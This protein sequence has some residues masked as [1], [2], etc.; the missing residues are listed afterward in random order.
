MSQSAK[1]PEAGRPRA[2]PVLA[3]RVP[4]PEDE[5]ANDASYAQLVHQATLAASM[6]DAPLEP[7]REQDRLLPAA[8]IFRIIQRELPEGCKISRDAKYFMQVR[9]LAGLHNAKRSKAGCTHVCKR[10]APVMS[11]AR[12]TDVPSP[13]E[14]QEALSEFVCFMTRFACPA[15][16][17]LLRDALLLLVL[18][19]H[20]YPAT[21]ILLPAPSLPTTL[22]HPSPA[23]T[24]Q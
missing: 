6:A 2:A 22:T 11:P 21:C 12:C 24:A 4:P 7:I 18:A 13:P 20:L 9:R 16:P 17:P 1:P 10:F 3:M 14:S 23:R 8:N 5:A 19:R 15:S